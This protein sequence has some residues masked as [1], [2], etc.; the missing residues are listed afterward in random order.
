MFFY[1][2][3]SSE[4]L[5]VWVE[6]MSTYLVDMRLV[7]RNDQVF[8]RIVGH[9]YKPEDFRLAEMACQMNY[10]QLKGPCPICKESG[11]TH[12]GHLTFGASI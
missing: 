8:F 6:L 10:H 9:W 3:S 4:E 2:I 12:C 7:V 1:Y 11:E 5:K